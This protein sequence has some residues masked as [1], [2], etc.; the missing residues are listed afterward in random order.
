[1][2]RAACGGIPRRRRPQ[3]PRERGTDDRVVTPPEAIPSG[4][5]SATGAPSNTQSTRSSVRT[6]RVSPAPQRIDLGQAMEPIR[7]LTM[8]GSR[9]ET[10]P[11]S[12]SITA[13]Q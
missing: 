13:N 12:V 10:A 5:S 7:P 4:R 11:P 9:A 3:T 8:S 6:Q 1:M 2:P